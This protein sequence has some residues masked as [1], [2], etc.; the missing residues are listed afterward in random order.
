MGGIQEETVMRVST[1][2]I[3]YTHGWNHK[4]NQWKGN[5]TT[6]INELIETLTTKTGKQWKTNT[7]ADWWDSWNIIH[8]IR[9]EW[10]CLQKKNW[11]FLLLWLSL[12]ELLTI[13]LRRK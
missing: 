13:L 5:L 12:K 3:H 4:A 7:N 6:E 2:K 9:V 1:I 11:D 10:A 8:C